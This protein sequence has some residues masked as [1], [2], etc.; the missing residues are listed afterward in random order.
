MNVKNEYK[1]LFLGDSISK[2]I[3]YDEEKKR[4][5]FCKK[6]F[7]NQLKGKIKGIIKNISRFGNTVL[8]AE[9]GI[10]NTLELKPDIAFIEMGGNDCDFDWKEVSINPDIDHKPNTEIEIY[11]KSLM[12]TA[13]SFKENGIECVFLTLPPIDSVR[14][15]KWIGKDVEK[16]ENILKWLGTVEK[17]YWWQEKYNLAIYEVAMASQSHLIDIRQGFLDQRDYRDLICLDGI[18][19]NEKGH[20]IIADKISKYLEVNMRYILN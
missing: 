20:K 9:N 7:A 6:S 14:Y 17:I 8:K 5:V 11:K 19:P 12:E 16:P 4:Y 1:L 13:K 3:I 18:H 10:K 2:G 15:Y